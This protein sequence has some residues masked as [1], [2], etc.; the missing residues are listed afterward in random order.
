MEGG[1]PGVEQDLSAVAR[2]LDSPGVASAL[3]GR[4]QCSGVCTTRTPAHRRARYLA[5]L[6]CSA[7]RRGGHGRIRCACE[8]VRSAHAPFQFWIGAG[9]CAH[10]R[11]SM[12]PGPCP[13]PRL[14]PL[15]PPH[16]LPRMSRHRMYA[17]TFATGVA[18]RARCET[19]MR[20]RAIRSD[21]FINRAPRPPPC[22]CN[23]AL[24]PKLDSRYLP[25]CAPARVL[26]HPKSDLHIAA[27]RRVSCLEE[28]ANPLPATASTAPV[29]HSPPRPLLRASAPLWRAH[30]RR[31]APCHLG[32]PTLGGMCNLPPVRTPAVPPTAPLI[33]STDVTWR[34]AN[35]I[36]YPERRLGPWSVDNLF[37]GPPRLLSAWGVSGCSGVLS[38]QTFRTALS[39]RCRL[40]TLRCEALCL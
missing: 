21:T 16:W 39:K 5:L 20:A 35:R 3:L 19:L 31:F 8:R 23:P 15:P 34:R 22:R 24:S 37:R 25:A 30:R 14:L 11:V 28:R 6:E 27:S 36:D 9:R 2:L 12:L 13:H 40:P 32:H 26:K 7:G 29:D 10:L 33:A 1:K 17:P 18:G 4:L 38:E